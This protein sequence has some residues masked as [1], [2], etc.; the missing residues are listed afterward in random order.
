M[1]E[2]GNLL[3]LGVTKGQL[4]LIWQP[5]STP[6]RPLPCIVFRSLYPALTGHPLYMHLTYNDSQAAKIFIPNPLSL[7]Q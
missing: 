2:S 1:E 4:V 3:D 5:L 7:I 6:K